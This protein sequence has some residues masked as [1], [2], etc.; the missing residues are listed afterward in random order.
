MKIQILSDIHNEFEIY[1]PK[2]CDADVVIL[3]GDIHTKNR[4]IEWAQSSFSVPV[5]YVLG[6]HEAYGKTLP[7]YINEIRSLT[8]QTNVTVLEKDVVTI[9]G[10]NF[11]GCTLWTDFE[12]MTNPR[13]AGYECQQVM[14]DYKKIKRV[15]I[16]WVKR[17]VNYVV[18]KI[19]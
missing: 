5:I 10:V 18:K 14:T 12:V 15:L 17:L 16:G 9:G 19:L 11:L 7:K 13:V 4:G 8:E 6:N 2:T 1:E 3:A